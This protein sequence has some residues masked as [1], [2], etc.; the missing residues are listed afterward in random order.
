M[1]TFSGQMVEIQSE[2]E[3]ELLQQIAE[4]QGKHSQLLDEKEVLKMRN[5]TVSSLIFKFAG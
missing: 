1:L 3:R 2:R 5:V 4:L